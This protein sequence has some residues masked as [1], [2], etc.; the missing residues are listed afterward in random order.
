MTRLQ[1]YLFWRDSTASGDA[2]PE[3]RS[4]QSTQ[5]AAARFLPRWL[6]LEQQAYDY[7]ECAA[8]VPGAAER[9][10]LTLLALSHWR[11]SRDA[12]SRVQQECGR[13]Q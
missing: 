12:K 1:E 10:R 8:R 2:N 7:A 5:R 11:A 13:R 3:V 9:D 4:M 6:Q